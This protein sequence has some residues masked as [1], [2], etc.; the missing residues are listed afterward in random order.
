MRFKVYKIVILLMVM[1]Q[2]L[3]A[4]NT[5]YQ[6]S[7]LDIT[8][9]LSINQV[10]S[11]FKDAD[12][13]MWFGTLSGLNR[14][15]GYKF[16]VFKHRANDAT[17]LGDNAI[18]G[19]FEGPGKKLW[20]KT[21]SG[22]SVYNA[23]TEKFSND[24]AR[25]LGKY[26]VLTDQLTS[27]KKDKQGNFWFLTNNE[28]LYCYDP[29]TNTTSFFNSAGNNSISILHSDAVTDVVEDS[30]KF[31]WLVYA[32]GE[33]DK[34]D[35]RTNTIVAH[36]SK[37]SKVNNDKPERYSAMIDNQDQ[38]WLFAADSP[39]GVYR[40]N[41]AADVLDHFNTETGTT[42]LNYNVI[43]TIIQ[44][45]DNKIWI[46]TDHGGINIINP[47]NNSVQYVLNKEDDAKSLRGNSA[48]LYK[49]NNGIIWAGTFKQGISYY[50]KSII[51]FP[52]V[53]HYLSDPKSLPYEDVDCFTDDA[54]GN[55]WIGTNGGGLVYYDATTKTYTQYKHNPSDPNSLANNIV[56]SLC[57]DHE[58]KLWIGTYFGGLDRF[59]GGRFIHYKHNWLLYKIK[60]DFIR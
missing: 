43:Y 54:K 59:E 46:G 47:A 9:G 26:K 15:D 28:G 41:Q 50:H 7:H 16:K 40:Y 30:R 22:F 37:L 57:I 38:L 60:T 31:M 27:I 53:R 5:A 35:T 18:A 17:S 44:A 3:Y 20:I 24:I 49:D 25:E 52:L 8:N 12:G 29:K 32:D 21:H 2:W 51:Q 48:V 56:I 6:F 33:I 34:L 19:I 1:Q 36:T 39:L 55:L 11:I 10:S 23:V 58:H 42:R 4:Q 13:F 45:D 14:Y